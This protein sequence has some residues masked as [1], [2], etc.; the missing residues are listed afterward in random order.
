MNF[1]GYLLQIDWPFG[2]ITLRVE[3]PKRVQYYTK[4]RPQMNF[5]SRA[6]PLMKIGLRSRV[7]THSHR[8]VGRLVISSILESLKTCRLEILMHLQS[9]ETQSSPVGMMCKSGEEGTS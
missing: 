5:L 7:F 3:H 8:L 9:I 4:S 1:E 2:G 6:L